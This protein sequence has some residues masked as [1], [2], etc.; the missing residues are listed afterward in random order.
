MTWD[1]GSIPDYDAW[2]ALGNP[3]WNWKTFIAA[4][5]KV[6]DF[7]DTKQD[8][9]LYGSRGVGH[10]GPIQTLINRFI[11]SPQG[12]FIPALQSLGLKNNLNSLDGNPLVSC[13]SRVTF[14]TSI[15]RDLIRL[16]ICGWLVPTCS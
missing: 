15:I 7:Q 6:E 3:G 13:T 5:M 4:M 1:R 11:F 9:E 8:R 2:E 10:G 12:G 14:A 16:P